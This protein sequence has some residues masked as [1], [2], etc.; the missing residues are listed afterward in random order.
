VG[1]VDGA[2]L[3]LVAAARAALQAGLDQ[4]GPGRPYSGVGAAVQRT[5][6]AAGLAVIPAFTGHG[7]GSYFH[8]PP[9][10]FPCRNSYPG[11]M[12]PGQT[13][14]VEPAVSEGG[15]G[16]RV[17][18]DGWTAVTQDNSRSAQFEHTVLITQ[19]GVEILTL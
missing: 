1:E 9:D 3:A 10:I 8:G 2:G 5:V 19:T 4:C 6:Q 11:L 17:L 7:I 12:Q 18:E 16:V 13:F 14:T 15:A